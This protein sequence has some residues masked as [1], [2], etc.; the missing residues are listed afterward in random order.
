M[1]KITVKIQGMSCSMCESH[2]NDTVR[3]QFAVK[4]I[5]SSHRKGQTEIIAQ[6]P[7]EEEAL[8]KAIHETGYTVLSIETKPYVKKE[9]FCH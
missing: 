1:V 4:K 5:S 7:L 8:Q 2:I 3:R 9:L 6:S